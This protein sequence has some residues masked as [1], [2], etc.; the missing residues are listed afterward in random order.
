[1]TDLSHSLFQSSFHYL[2]WEK[3]G[4][5]TMAERYEVNY[6]GKLLGLIQKRYKEYTFKHPHS[7]PKESPRNAV[8]M[9]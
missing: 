8:T 3:A 1:M 4:D 6:T 9:L 7:C 5:I 2:T